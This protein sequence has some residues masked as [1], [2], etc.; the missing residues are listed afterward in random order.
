MIPWRILFAC[1]AVYVCYMSVDKNSTWHIAG[2]PC[3]LALSHSFKKVGRLRLCG[4]GVWGS[5]IRQLEWERKWRILQ[6][7]V[8]V[9]TVLSQSI[10]SRLS[11]PTWTSH[12]TFKATV[13]LALSFPLGLVK[14]AGSLLSDV[15]CLWNYCLHSFY[16]SR[17]VC[18]MSQTNRV[19]PRTLGLVFL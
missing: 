8:E 5:E 4:S 3:L 7:F 1:L 6:A 10:W 2:T 14:E 11:D 12:S 17:R 16:W 19:V 9:D 15:C 18:L 13:H